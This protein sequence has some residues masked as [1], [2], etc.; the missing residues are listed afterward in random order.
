MA[1][2]YKAS[3]LLLVLAILTLP[4]RACLNDRDSL[5]EEVRGLPDVV[6][7]ITGRFERNP[8]LYYQMRL[9]RVS[10]EL[11]ARPALLS[12]YDDAGVAC[13]RLGHDND[14]LDWM[15]EKRAHMAVY[16]PNNATIKEQW[17]RYYANDGTFRIHRWIRAG[18]DRTRLGQVVQARDEIA[19]AIE[20]KP[21]AHFGREKYQLMVMNWIIDPTISHFYPNTTSQV[22]ALPEYVEMQHPDRQRAVKGLSGLIAL[23]NAWES[24]DIFMA[25]AVMLR[26]RLRHADR[27]AELAR[28][29]Y[30]ELLQQGQHSLL[31]RAPPEYSPQIP[32][33]TRKGYWTLRHEADQW[34][35]RRTAYMMARL[36]IGRHPD[37]DPTFWNDWHDAGPPQLPVPLDKNIYNRLGRPLG[38]DELPFWGV[39]LIVGSLLSLRALVAL[40]TA[41]ANYLNVVIKRYLDNR[42]ARKE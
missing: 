19:R 16:T 8:P 31:L 33:G 28:L 30:A 5:A 40:L 34:Q 20:I 13:D 3:A 29:R 14:A 37:T 12:D 35:A 23:G 6:Q 7:I 27:I 21:N 39:I 38:I 9:T 1:G 2:A 32:E 11:A 4:A 36:Q 41:A 18:A 25:L 17:Y 22:V 15:R 10:A 42:I 24:P 26:Y